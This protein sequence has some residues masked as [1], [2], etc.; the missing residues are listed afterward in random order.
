MSRSG[1]M[2]MLL[3]RQA[4]Q[5]LDS[6]VRVVDERKMEVNRSGLVPRLPGS[7]DILLTFKESTSIC[8]E[9]EQE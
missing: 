7:L 5:K 3:S 8:V 4:M 2:L 9:R 6:E 1:V